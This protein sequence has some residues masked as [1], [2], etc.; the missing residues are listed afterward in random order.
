MTNPDDPIHA[1]IDTHTGTGTMGLTKRE[2]FAAM[3]MKG[4]FSEKGFVERFGAY[5]RS[6]VWKMI[7]ENSIGL[8]DALITALNKTE[9]K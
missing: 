7:A 8:A 6:E 4:A 1:W 3:A 2:Y 9:G 5:D